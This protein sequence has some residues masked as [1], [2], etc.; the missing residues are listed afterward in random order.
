MLATLPRN[1]TPYKSKSSPHGS[2]WRITAHERRRGPIVG[3]HVCGEERGKCDSTMSSRVGSGC[4]YHTPV[5]LLSIQ[6]GSLVP[7]VVHVTPVGFF[8]I[9]LDPSLAIPLKYRPYATK[10]TP[11]VFSC[12]VSTVCTFRIFRATF[13]LQLFRPL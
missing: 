2:D 6:S 5:C 13:L 8:K 3:L 4:E 7:V 11:T 9:T 12:I 1:L 10:N